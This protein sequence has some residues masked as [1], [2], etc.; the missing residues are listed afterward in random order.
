MGLAVGAAH[1][2]IAVRGLPDLRRSPLI[3]SHDAVSRSLDYDLACSF[4]F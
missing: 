3:G 2:G 1:R 4:S